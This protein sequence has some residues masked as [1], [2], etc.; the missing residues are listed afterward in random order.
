MNELDN[1]SLSSAGHFDRS[2]LC[3][4]DLGYFPGSPRKQVLVFISVKNEEIEAGGRSG[5]LP[6]VIN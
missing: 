4:D 2:A 6:K 5:A 3:V 1:E